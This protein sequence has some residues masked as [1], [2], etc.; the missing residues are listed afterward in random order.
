MDSA[1]ELQEIFYSEI[2]ITQHM[3][4]QVKKLTAQEIQ[5]CAPIHPNM[6]HKSTAF[7][8]SLYSVAVLTGWGLLHHI[9][10]HE[11]PEAHIVIFESTIQFQIPVRQDFCASCHI[12]DP[13][14]LHPF[15]HIFRK[16]G[17]AKITLH[18]QIAVPEGIAVSFKGT[19]VAHV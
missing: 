15:L 7:G 10:R 18:V 4:L 3:G 9:L 12:H 19:Y 8:G 11:T 13:Q 5:V 14:Q 2:P 1:K 6:N 17:R 16:K